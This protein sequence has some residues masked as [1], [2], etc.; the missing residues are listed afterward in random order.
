MSAYTNGTY[1]RR[2]FG[3]IVQARREGP[4]A[5]RGGSGNRLLAGTVAGVRSMRWK[6][7]ALSGPASALATNATGWI[8]MQDGGTGTVSGTVKVGN[9]PVSRKV[10]LLDLSTLRLVRQTW[11]AADGSYSFALVATG[12]DFLLLADDYTGTYNDV[13]AARVRAV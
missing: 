1:L 12:R 9:L 6:S 7:G 11:S 2:L 5:G 10:S 4:V 13:A 8:D 3:G